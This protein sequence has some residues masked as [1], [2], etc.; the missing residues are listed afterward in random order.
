MPSGR[1]ARLK[2]G[3]HSERNSHLPLVAACPAYKKARLGYPEQAFGVT[4]I[5]FLRLAIISSAT[6]RGASA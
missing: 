1:E 3:L 2:A 5:Y 4:F 6:L